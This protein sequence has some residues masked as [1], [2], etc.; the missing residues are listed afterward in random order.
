MY[1][2]GPPTF[3]WTEMSLIAEPAWREPQHD[4]MPV[5]QNELSFITSTDPGNDAFSASSPS[6]S[7]AFEGG[8]GSPEPPSDAAAD[9]A[10]NTASRNSS[11]GEEKATL[12]A[13]AE[14]IAPGRADVIGRFGRECRDEDRIL[15]I[16]TTCAKPGARCPGRT[17]R[18]RSSP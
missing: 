2:Y 7:T 17:L 8:G 5:M 14:G 18:S 16:P 11:D 12:R 4:S 1:L 3:C 9:A 6:L 10:A 15:R 13:K